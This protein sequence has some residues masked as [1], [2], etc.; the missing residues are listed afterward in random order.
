MSTVVIAEN[1]AEFDVFTAA[2]SGMAAFFD[3]VGSIAQWMESQGIPESNSATY[4]TAL[5]R[6]L[7]SMAGRKDA[8]ELKELSREC[9]TAGGLNEQV[10][11]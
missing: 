2:S 1:E 3:L 9:Q 10:F 5:F 11:D 4:V 6:A 7:T 8:N